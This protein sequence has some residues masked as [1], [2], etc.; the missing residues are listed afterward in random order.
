MT[1]VTLLIILAVAALSAS[2]VF[3]LV[4]TLYAKY[5]AVFVNIL[6]VT[7]HEDVIQAAYYLLVDLAIKG[8]AR[9]VKDAIFINIQHTVEIIEELAQAGEI[10]KSE[11]KAKA[12][13]V[14]KET[15][16]DLKIEYLPQVESLISTAIELTITYLGFRKKDAAA[17]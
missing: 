6:K 14:I 11:R 5:P 10:P 3:Y 16:K 2:A 9:D 8:L 4:P 17:G 15:L 1:L 12:M 13:S 7:S